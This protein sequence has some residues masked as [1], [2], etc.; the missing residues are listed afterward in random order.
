MLLSDTDIKVLFKSY[1]R[2]SSGYSKYIYFNWS[3]SLTNIEAK[4]GKYYS[5][6]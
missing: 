4:N 5:D 3:S 1:K 6:F 2:H